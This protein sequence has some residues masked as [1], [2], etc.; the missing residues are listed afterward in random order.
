MSSNGLKDRRDKESLQQLARQRGDS[1]DSAQKLKEA[2]DLAVFIAGL[3]K[4]SQHLNDDITKADQLLAEIEGKIGPLSDAIDDLENSLG[5]GTDGDIYVGNGGGAWAQAASPLS[6]GGIIEKLSSGGSKIWRQRA[7]LNIC[8][9]PT[10]ITTAIDNPTGDGFESLEYQWA[11]PSDAGFS[12]PPH[13]APADTND[14]RFW[15]SVYDV[16]TTTCKARVKSFEAEPTSSTFRLI[17][18]GE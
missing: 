16:T 12:S 17:A 6:G 8:L 3:K 9:S 11:F 7:G 15:V 18:I 2:R 10:F 14:R 5:G 1:A 13:V 4:Q